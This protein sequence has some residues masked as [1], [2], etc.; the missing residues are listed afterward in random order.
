MNKMSG[1][2]QTAPITK[3]EREAREA[4]RQVEAKHAI[5]DHDAARKAFA[6]NYERLKAERVAREAARATCY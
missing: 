4:F 3:V 1:E 2:V 5:T 6:K